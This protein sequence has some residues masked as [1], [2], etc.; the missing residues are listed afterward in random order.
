MPANYH[1][2]IFFLDYICIFVKVYGTSSA[3]ISFVLQ[4]I[5]CTHIIL[6]FHILILSS[7]FQYLKRGFC[8]SFSKLLNAVM[9]VA[10]VPENKKH[11]TYL[12]FANEF[13]RTGTKQYGLKFKF[14]CF[15]LLPPSL[16]RGATI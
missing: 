2:C 9:S 12:N 11:C 14:A 7:Y 10:K 4:L 6:L 8:R 3:L 1:F 13:K 5:V 16:R 15:W